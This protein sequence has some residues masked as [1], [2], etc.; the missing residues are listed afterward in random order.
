[1]EE[2][3]FLGDRP[4]CEADRTRAIEATETDWTR[5]GILEALLV[6]AFVGAVAWIWEGRMLPTHAGLGVHD[7]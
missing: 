2:I 5:A 3:G 4:F 6:V 7:S 1:M